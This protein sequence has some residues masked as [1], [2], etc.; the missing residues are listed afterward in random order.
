MEMH[1]SKIH[2]SCESGQ[3]SEDLSEPIL[4]N[5]FIEI[6]SKCGTELCISLREWYNWDCWSCRGEGK[7]EQQLFQ[8][9]GSPD[10]LRV[11]L[12]L[13]TRV[14]AWHP[15][16]QRGWHVAGPDRSWF[17]RKAQDCF[18]RDQKPSSQKACAW[19]LAVVQ[20]LTVQVRNLFKRNWLEQNFPKF[21]AK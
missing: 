5:E 14:A 12:S 10:F 11:W 18:R 4:L 20:G 19:E 7:G 9:Q 15:A 2:N 6:K 16:P 8:N 17:M 1:N 13:E 3:E 21:Q